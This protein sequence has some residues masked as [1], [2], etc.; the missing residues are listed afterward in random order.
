MHCV[1]LHPDGGILLTGETLVD[2][3]KGNNAISLWDVG[4]GELT[5]TLKG[6]R[7]EPHMISFSPD[8]RQILSATGLGWVTQLWDVDSGDELK[9]FEG[10][11]CCFTP[12]GQHAFA[13]S[14][15][16]GLVLWDLKT[17]S[18]RQ[19]FHRHDKVVC[20]AVSADG[21]RALSGSMDMTVKVWGLPSLQN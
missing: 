13:N 18:E 1:A 20:V 7:G 9:S 4:S 2:G 16:N 6:V 14:K 19:R 11:S 5:R 17:G 3:R 21:R 12:D 15:D 10:H 8:G